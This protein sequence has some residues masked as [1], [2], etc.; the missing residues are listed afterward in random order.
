M[1]R[2][3]LI[4]EI[5]ATPQAVKI[6]VLTKFIDHFRD[7]LSDDVIQEKFSLVKTDTGFDVTATLRRVENSDRGIS[8]FVD[9]LLVEL[10]DFEDIEG[11]LDEAKTQSRTLADPFTV[12]FGSACVLYIMS[13]KW[14]FDPEAGF[15]AEYAGLDS[16]DIKEL[17][18]KLFRVFNDS[19]Q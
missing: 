1:D 5:Q 17:L 7:S 16:K 18:Q 13:I 11:A 3:R 4:Q 6:V 19:W 15:Q 9:A 12:M 14:E 10:S 8:A 2:A